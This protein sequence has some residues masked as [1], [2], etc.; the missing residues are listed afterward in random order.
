MQT[1]YKTNDKIYGYINNTQARA[2]PAYDDVI[3]FI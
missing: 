2:F 3:G 1:N